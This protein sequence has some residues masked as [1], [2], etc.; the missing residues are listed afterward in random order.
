LLK[1]D[2][3]EAADLVFKGEFSDRKCL[4]CDWYPQKVSSEESK[5]SQTVKTA[6]GISK[7]ILV[8]K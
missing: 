4:K 7:E 2:P 6:T 1:L 3:R 8:Q 5:K